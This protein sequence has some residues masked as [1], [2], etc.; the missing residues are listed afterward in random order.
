MAD[1]MMVADVD[2][3]LTDVTTESVEAYRY[4]SEGVMMHEELRE[5][6]A[7]PLLEKAVEI[8]PDFAMALAKL[9]TSYNN[10]GEGDKSREYSL[11]AME[12]L[13]RVNDRERFYIEGRHYSL[14]QETV[15]QAIEAYQ[16]AVEAY[17]D[18]TAARNN[19]AQQ[20]IGLERFDEAIDHL[21]ELRRSKMRFPGTYAS[22]ASAYGMTGRFDEGLDVLVEYTVDNPENAAGYRNLAGHLA[23]AGRYDEAIDAIEKAE[24]AGAPAFDTD[25]LRWQIAALSDDWGTAEDMAETLAESDDP[26]SQG[27]ALFAVMAQALYEGDLE[28]AYE[29]FDDLI[30]LSEE[31]FGS[32]AR[33][34]RSQVQ[35]DTGDAEGA[36]AIAAEMSEV[37]GDNF[38]RRIN[39]MGV[40]ATALAQMGERAA[41]NEVIIA[42]FELAQGISIPERLFRRQ[43]RT[44]R[45]A[46]A[47]HAQD[48]EGTIDFIAP[49]IDEMPMMEEIGNSQRTR[50]HYQLG[51]AYL[52]TDDPDRAETNFLRGLEQPGRVY[53][54]IATVRSLWH[55]G[56]IYESRGDETRARQYY[57]RFVDYWGSGEIDEANVE[58]AEDFLDRTG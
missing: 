21:E 24:A 18:H 29:A 15:G 28:D 11:R 2:A 36:L 23:W 33:N 26:R 10:I 37:A 58:H 54:P 32:Q 55:L 39:A 9:A 13:D 8:D 50:L 17:P 22:L 52:E 3:D 38:G 47:F 20:L 5:D 49:T 46:V 6:E 14:E 34:I 16:K 51:V 27:S 57:E 19:L 43:E 42:M 44:F 30:A 53:D 25:T 31:N 40:E 12:N 7:I 45:G 1:E 35:L 56:R 41:S 4:Y 48:W